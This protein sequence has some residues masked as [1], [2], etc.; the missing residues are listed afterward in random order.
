METDSKYEEKYGMMYKHKFLFGK[1]KGRYIGEISNTD[2]PYLRWLIDNW[3]GERTKF[4]NI[5]CGWLGTGTFSK[6]CDDKR[7][8]E[9]K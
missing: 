1:Y 6:N 4:Y 2:L 3:T 5:L 8:L 7:K 9:K